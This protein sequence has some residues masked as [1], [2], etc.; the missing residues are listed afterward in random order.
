MQV[1]IFSKK[2]WLKLGINAQH[3][4]HNQH[5][6][7]ATRPGAGIWSV[8]RVGRG[9]YQ[10]RADDPIETYAGS[11]PEMD[12]I[13]VDRAAATATIAT[14]VRIKPVL[15][16]TSTRLDAAGVAARRCEE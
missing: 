10:I 16:N 1:G 7:I 15:S 2:P 9:L 5:L 6:P 4:M 8:G 14:S 12:S 11:S 3:I 13:A